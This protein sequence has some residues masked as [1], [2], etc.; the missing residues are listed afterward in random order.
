MGADMQ[1]IILLVLILVLN[2][3]ADNFILSGDW[4]PI[5]SNSYAMLLGF[6]YKILETNLSGKGALY[7]GVSYFYQEKSFPV[8]PVSYAITLTP[9]EYIS[10][11]G[12]GFK[13]TF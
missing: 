10:K 13:F 9:V 1:K 5:D 11:I 7:V 8:C 3:G 6:N 2:C 4:I 12:I